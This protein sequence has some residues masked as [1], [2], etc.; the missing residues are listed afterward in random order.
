VRKDVTPPLAGGAPAAAAQRAGL[1]DPPALSQEEMVE[2]ALSRL[3]FGPQKEDRARVAQL[4]IEAFVEE[5][6]HPE[7]ID[8]SALEQRLASY[9]VLH[10]GTVELV[11]QLI[12]QRKMRQEE[13]KKEQMQGPRKA[14]G[15]AP[16]GAGHD[17]V[18]QLSQAK[19]LRAVSS[20]RQLQEELTD[21]WFNHF[22]VFAGKDDEAALLPDYEARALRPNALGTFPELL[23]ATA[24][25]PAML[26]YLDNWTSYKKRHPDQPPRGDA[27]GRA[28][29]PAA[30]PAAGAP[31]TRFA[32]PRA[33][34]RAP[35]GAGAAPAAKA[36]TPSCTPSGRPIRRARTSTRRTSSSWARPASGAPLTAGWLARCARP[37]GRHRCGIASGRH[38]L[39]FP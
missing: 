34:L 18:A 31:V 24:H 22:N 19:L 23:E 1:A 35:S 6:L 26:I 14:P 9:D 7:Q 17:Y 11:Q 10:Q 33:R 32:R 16:R 27:H 4:G 25:S 36:R 20:R 12:A 8:D 28:A 37:R 39:A 2:H 5:Q 15:T 29:L 38:R 3:T 13:Q 30:S 21:F